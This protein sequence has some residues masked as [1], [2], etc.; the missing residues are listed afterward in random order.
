M[1][2]LI[3]QEA[4]GR[5]KLVDQFAAAKRDVHEALAKALSEA[6]AQSGGEYDFHPAEALKYHWRV[7]AAGNSSMRHPHHRL[8]AGATVNLRRARLLREETAGSD[9]NGAGS[10]SGGVDVLSVFV[11]KRKQRSKERHEEAYRLW[12]LESHPNKGL[13]LDLAR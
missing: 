11:E 9:G 1:S 12:A 13:A 5:Q 6:E 10:S 3:H 8:P 2:T 7:R 4:R